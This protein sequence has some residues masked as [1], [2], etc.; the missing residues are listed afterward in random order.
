MNRLYLSLVCVAMALISVGCC[1]PMG[2]GPGCGVSDC[3]DCDGV[4]YG[5]TIIP[6]RPLDGLRQFRKRLVCGSGCGEVYYGEWTSTPPD[7]EDPCCG[8]QWVGGA[9][10]CRPGCWQP[11]SLLGNLYGSRFCSGDESSA[12]CGCGSVECD[13][14]C[15]EADGFVGGYI[16]QGT[17][18]AR[19]VVSGSSCGCAKASPV[20]VPS[21]M[22]RR[23]VPATDRLTR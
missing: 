10:P 12:S 13:G 22:V 18:V 14:G 23:S 19:P 5:E 15:G 1:G 3:Y 7:C 6:Q 21:R 11:G 17:S 8:D 20:A 16:Q 2:C 4:G 9:V